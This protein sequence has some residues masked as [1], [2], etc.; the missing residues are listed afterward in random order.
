MTDLGPGADAGADALHSSRHGVEPAA[1]AEADLVRELSHLHATRHETFLHAPVDALAEH[2]SR[3]V[4][5]ETEW[6]RRHPEREV[7]LNRTRDGAR[8][9]V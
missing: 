5:L 1:L 8:S 6:V 3:T 4:A 7:D 2:T 9:R